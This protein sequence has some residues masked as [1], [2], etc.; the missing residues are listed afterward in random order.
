M[1][2]DPAFKPWLEQ[3]L[4]HMVW[5]YKWQKLVQADLTGILSRTIPQRNYA[6]A[7][8]PRHGKTSLVT[9]PLPAYFLRHN[10]YSEVI[11]AMHSRTIM[12]KISRQTRRIVKEEVGLSDEVA[13]VMEWETTIGGRYRGATPG[14]M[15]AGTGADLIVADDL[16]P[17]R[18]RAESEVFRDALS[19]WWDDDLMRRRNPQPGGILA[20]TVLIMT[21]WHSDDI[22]AR[23]VNPD[24]WLIRRLP[25]LYDP[26]EEDNFC[27][28]GRTRKNEPLCSD[29]WTEEN[30]LGFKANM[31]AYS[32]QALYQGLPTSKAGLFFDVT[33]FDCSY[34]FTPEDEPVDSRVRYFDFAA[35]QSE[36]A[37]YTATV[38][39][40][41]H[42]DGTFTIEEMDRVQ[43]GPGPR[44]KWQ[45]AKARMD[46]KLFG[47]GKVRQVEEKQPGA[48]GK[49]RVR[50]FHKLMRGHSIGVDK[51]EGEGNKTTRA[52]PFA[53]SVSA[54]L[55]RIL[56][57]SPAGKPNPI[58][59]FKNELR[60]FPLGKFKD[61]VDAGSGAH[62]WLTRKGGEIRTGAVSARKERLLR[63]VGANVLPPPIMSTRKARHK[64]SY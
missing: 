44:D 22:W 5:G 26:D 61:W 39:M 18:K 23:K 27:P 14:T 41:I 57:T 52:D 47:E 12:S 20:P 1:R 59:A 51:I 40:A 55:V 34:N 58:E 25:A 9:I 53:A 56:R 24:D 19:D 15:I 7:A 11:T 63:Q 62:N 3:R 2:L 37:A 6:I 60:A 10:P 8:P 48:A 32:W 36:D 28:L 4:S 17:D 38:L 33:M 16:V 35:T 45:R 42:R 43:E 30:L 46:A 13:N 50:A 31:S 54:G 64:G 49:D 29:M 21:R